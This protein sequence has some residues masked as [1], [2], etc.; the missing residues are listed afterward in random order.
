PAGD[1]SR[2][3]RVGGGRNRPVADAE[4]VAV[5]AG[6]V[7]RADAHVAHHLVLDTRGHFI[8][9]RPARTV[10]VRIEGGDAGEAGAGAEFGGLELAVTVRIGPGAVV[11]RVREGVDP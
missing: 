1:G 6:V 10:G 8:G 7:N 3:R 4:L 5:G 2:E 11:R 9:V